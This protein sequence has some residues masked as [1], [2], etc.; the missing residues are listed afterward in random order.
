MSFCASA[1]R[2]LLPWLLCLWPRGPGKD[3]EDAGE[4]T[5]K[6]R[7]TFKRFLRDC[8][9]FLS[10]NYAKHPFDDRYRI[11]NDIL[12]TFVGSKLQREAEL[13]GNFCLS[14][15]RLVNPASSAI[16]TGDQLGIEIIF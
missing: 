9:N 14:F 12:K 3:K 10:I 5:R 4:Q 1:Q 2:S 15:A 6:D 13:K 11:I 7:N 8:F 16:V